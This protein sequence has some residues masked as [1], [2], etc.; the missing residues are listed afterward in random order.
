MR[1][2]SIIY[3]TIFVTFQGLYSDS[4]IK[5]KSYTESYYYGGVV[6][7]AEESEREIWIGHNKLC[8]ISDNWK[9]ILDI[10]QNLMVI[11]NREDSSY[12]ECSLP[13]EWSKVVSP[14][15]VGML[16][17]FETKG[18]VTPTGN[19]KKIDNWECQ[20]YEVNSYI[21]YQGSKINENDTKIWAS[22]EVLSD[23]KNFDQLASIMRK[24]ANYDS[25]YIQ[26]LGKITGYHVSRESFFYP[27]GFSVASIQKIVEV[28]EIDP[29]V[30]LYE[31]P[32]GY[33]KKESLSLEEIRNL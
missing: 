27:K 30:D 3:I 29:P 15:L 22:S 11:I 23:N 9:F 21:L 14:E 24:F 26:Q 6:Q 2:S 13:F 25:S 7:P 8:S 19:K 18:S 28:V 5:E 33:S 4:R 32:T 31:I 10:N 12:V 20:E 17:S 16:K 1:I